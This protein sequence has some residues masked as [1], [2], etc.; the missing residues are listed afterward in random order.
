[1]E[2]LKDVL[3]H[4]ILEVATSTIT[5]FE[6]TTGVLKSRYP[7]RDREALEL[8]I[9]DLTILDFTPRDA[10]EA[11]VIRADLENQGTKIGPYDLLI[12]A[13]AKSNDLTLITN[14]TREF[15]RV[16]GLRVENWLER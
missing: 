1:V 13:I 10:K 11:A 9:E 12:A 3:S 4:S 6:L 2:T 16:N 7:L 15:K 5:L 8:M 14:N